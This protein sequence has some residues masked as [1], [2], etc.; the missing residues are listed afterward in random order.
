MQQH[1]TK[2]NRQMQI[3]TNIINNRKNNGHFN[4]YR[5]RKKLD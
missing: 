2:P 1:F 4:H 5:F 3:Q